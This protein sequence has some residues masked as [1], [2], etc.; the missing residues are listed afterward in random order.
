MPANKAT[1]ANRAQI[2]MLHFNYKY[3]LSYLYLFREGVMLGG[4]GESSPGPYTLGK[5]STR[6]LA[7]LL[8]HRRTYT[9]ILGAASN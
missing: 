4:G 1:P 6:E 2:I 5:G 9:L 8:S 3:V 7:Y